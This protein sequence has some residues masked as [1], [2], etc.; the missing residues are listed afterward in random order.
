MLKKSIA[1]AVGAMLVA[2]S[3]SAVEWS[4]GG[5]GDL[6]MAPLVM[7]GGGWST[8]MKVINNSATDSAVAKVVFH[9]PGI[10]EE[11]LDF[12]IFLSPGDVWTGTVV[13]NADGSVGVSS[14]DPSSVRFQVS[15]TN[16][17]PVAGTNTSGF[18]PAVAKF[19]TPHP[20]V[21]A[22]IFQSRMIRGLGAA[23][24]AKSAIFARY[25]E[26]CAN[27][28][29]NPITANDT[30]NVLSGT[31]TMANPLNGNKLTLAMT[32]LA[33]YDNRFYLTPAFFT[34]LA[35][36]PAFSTKQQVEDALWSSNFTL[37]F[38]NAAG[39]LTY[40][41]VTFPTKET[42]NNSLN[43]QYAPFPGPVPVS[44][45][46]RNEEEE[47]LGVTEAP[48]CSFSPCPVLT[49]PTAP[50][51]PNELNVIAIA[52]GGVFG[53]ST[54]SQ[55]NTQTFT[56]GW[57]NL[58]IATDVSD[59]AGNARWNNLGAAGSPALVTYINW[60]FASG[61]LQ[62]TWQYAPKSYSGVGN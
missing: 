61:S 16:G 20:I 37:P 4:P 12:L 27:A 2:G 57:V 36:N 52:S 34:G 22:N 39:N 32:A 47:I 49:Q 38:S 62:G 50:R 1:A 51:L 14:A 55:I 26:L 56:K 30:D 23:P 15:N 11:V 25:A 43:S 40:A 7:T 9:G 19:T 60:D 42:F 59:T 28:A 13:R 18:D 3:A 45:A 33:N 21:Y 10:S 35:T 53:D 29:N 8:E 54:G 6:L 17:C 31:V 46:V 24:V 58:G 41:T 5:K 48:R 44:F